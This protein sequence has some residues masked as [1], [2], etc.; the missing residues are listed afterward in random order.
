MCTRWEIDKRV[1]V[2]VVNIKGVKL[3]LS[4]LQLA[5]EVHSL[6]IVVNEIVVVYEVSVVTNY[7]LIPKCDLHNF[8][9]KKC[10]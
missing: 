2:S 1:G 9:K 7:S 8:S 6:V 5:R 4:V 10:F 3:V